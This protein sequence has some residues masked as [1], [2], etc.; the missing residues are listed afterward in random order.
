MKTPQ[1]IVFT[2]VLTMSWVVVGTTACYAYLSIN[3]IAP[4]EKVFSALKD[5]GIF[6][7]GALG[8]ILANTRSA[9]VKLDESSEEVIK[10]S[11]PESTSKGLTE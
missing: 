3:A 5:A 11:L 10:P 9:E 1:G 2:V 6:A 8:G 4:D 7:L